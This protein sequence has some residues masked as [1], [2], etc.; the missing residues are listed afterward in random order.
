MNSLRLR[1]LA[2]TSL[3]MTISFAVLGAAIDRSFSAALEA[4]HREVLESQALALLAA[5]QAEADELVL[6]FDMPEAKLNAPD[7]GLYA[8]IR[9]EDGSVL[10]RSGSSIGIDLLPILALP[11]VGGRIMARQTAATGEELDVLNLGVVW[12]FDDGSERYYAFSVAESRRALEQQMA[13][14]R[15]Q[16]YLAFV[17][18]AVFLLITV[19]LLLSWL[20]RPLGQ[21]EDEIEAV[22]SGDRQQLS[23]NYPSE[24][25]GVARNL[26][27]LL[28]SEQKRVTRYQQTLANLAHSLKTPLAAAKNLLSSEP[29]PAVEKEL[30]RMQDIVRY[31]LA[32]PAAA[33]GR[34]VGRGKIRVEPEI[35]ELLDGL[36]KVYRAKQVSAECAIEPGLDFAGDRG[37][38]IEMVGNLLDNAYKWC[39]RQ[40]IVSARQRPLAD[41]AEWPSIEFVVEDDGPGIPAEAATEALT[42]GK[43]LDESTPGSGIGLSVVSEL[44]TLYGGTVSIGASDTLGGVSIQLELRAS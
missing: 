4:A 35:I 25:T 12:E 39:D 36:D 34:L 42:R 32:R 11:P 5:A 10:W 20:L 13:S 22:E 44:A 19:A 21:I 7:S 26:N 38:L 18:I 15:G 14:F 30:D 6:P 31:Q 24:L 17:V 41:D 27:A 37:D 1:L 9:R 29:S 40:V 23:E 43:R 2:L 16:L 28:V 33:S 3:L 8:K